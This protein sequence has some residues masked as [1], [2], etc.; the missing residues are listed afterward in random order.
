MKQ[1]FQVT[2]MT[3]SA[4]SAHVE[5]NVSQVS[6]VDA[7]Q[8]NLLAGTM[9]VSYDAARTDDAE[10]I[11]AVT[12]AGYGASVRGTAQAQPSAKDITAEET[13]KMRQRLTGSLIFLV[14]LLYISMGHMV[15]L[16]LPSFLHGTENAMSFALTQLLLT[17]PIAV[18]NRTFFINGVKTLWHRA[19]NMDS[20]IAVGAGAAL[21]YGIFALYQISWGL[22]HGDAAR[23]HTYVSDLYF[24][25]AGMILTLITVG[26]YLESRAKGKTGAALEALLQLAPKTA[27]VERN[28][29]ETQVPIEEVQVGDIVCVRPGESIAVDGEIVFGQTV[30]DESALTGESM[31]VEKGVGDT[32]YAA[33]IN[34]SGFLRF[35]AAK[36]GQD[37]TL[38]Q[39][40]RLVDEASASK[41]PIA[42]LADRISGVFVPTVLAIAGL[43][44]IIWL[45]LG[46][47]FSF[48]LATGIAVLVISCPCALGLATPVAIMVGTGI[49]ASMGVLF[50]SAEA[51]EHLQAVQT[52]VLDKTGTV[53]QG[54]PVVTDVRQAQTISEPD[55]LQIAL[56]LE[57][58]SEH[59][60][61][62][63]VVQYA[64]QQGAHSTAVDAFTETAG[65]GITG[66]IQGTV[67]VAGN[68]RMMQEN[69]IALDKWQTE[70]DAL[71]Q[72][73]KT[74]LFFAK[75]QT[76]MGLLAI[77]DVI[78]PTSREAVQTL[79]ALGH[80]VVM[81]TGDHQK[82]AEAVQKQIGIDKVIAEIL[83]QD[84]ERVV[85]QLQEQGKRVVMIG[86]GINDAPAL[87][88]ADV[89]IAIGAGTDVAIASADV[90]LMKS[91]LMDAVDAIRLSRKTLRNIRQN[92][93][94]A[95]FYNCIGIPLA[96]GVFYPMF[97]LQL[98]PAFGAAAMSLSSFCVVTNALRLRLFKPMP[99]MAQTQASMQ[100]TIQPIQQEGEKMM[101]K[102]IKIEG[103]MC[104]HC[105]GHV[106]KALLALDGVTEAQVSHESGTA[107]VTCA[108]T[109]TEES[110]THAVAEAGYT[111]TGI[112]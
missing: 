104:T 77:A 10:I 4:C 63:A 36:V 19:P 58:H 100:T 59:P 69:G 74:P 105:S 24:E 39:I 73:G 85:R 82:T 81:L 91:D 54:Q 43:S 37:T 38:A 96:A 66:T 41:A 46:Q 40:I 42:K 71:A 70:A 84:K 26:K 7:V 27:V 75:A 35:R 15:G 47:S 2:N 79:Q 5:K 64:R 65:R 68:A 93:F 20:L 78:K 61:A 33:T 88:R 99:R 30:L 9:A 56:S 6:G 111:V 14:L 49:G 55:F 18:L 86:D 44:V 107:V 45:L 97:A 13:Q 76:I 90:V 12:D 32:V 29:K 8:V 62:K 98:S 52:V 109:V 34:Q 112:A 94:W 89:G 83:P 31:P 95:F 16:P 92:L 3:C 67:Y 25:S 103:M 17:L 1:Q 80:E 57:E 11:K 87:A 48:A 51:L 60:L 108:D 28:G 21:V 106:Q 102:T 101:Q 23:V 72:A 110:L 53:T 22:G 50:K